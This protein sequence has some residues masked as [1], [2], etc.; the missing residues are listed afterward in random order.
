MTKTIVRTFKLPMDCSIVLEL[1]GSFTNP[2]IRYKRISPVREDART[3]QFETLRQAKFAFEK[4]TNNM[5]EVYGALW[6][7]FMRIPDKTND[8]DIAAAFDKSRELHAMGGEMTELS[9]KLEDQLRGVT[10]H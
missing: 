1:F 7:T 2:E 8:A 6:D 4:M 9:K 5:T 3:L 10:K